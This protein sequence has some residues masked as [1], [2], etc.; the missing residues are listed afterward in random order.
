MS[1][2]AQY[3]MERTDTS[4]IETEEGFIT[5]KPWPNGMYIE[6]LFINKD[7][8]F[9]GAA[10]RLADQVAVIAKEQGFKSLFGSICPSAKGSTEGMKVL[11]AY[12]F[13]L[14][15][16]ANNFIVFKKDL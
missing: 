13:K 3:L 7:H 1:L 14:D 11:L 6:D 12:G 9:N 16:S 4:I 10:S 8:R 2:F 5:F 15:S